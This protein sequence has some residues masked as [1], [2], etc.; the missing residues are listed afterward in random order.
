LRGEEKR[1]YVYKKTEYRII[2]KFGNIL[3]DLA[4]R[5]GILEK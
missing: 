5:N 1:K 2:E 3:W 4:V